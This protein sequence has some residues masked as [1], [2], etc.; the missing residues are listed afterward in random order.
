MNLIETVLKLDA[1]A[2]KG[3]WV[4]DLRGEFVDWGAVF[5]DI[6]VATATTLTGD[7]SIQK[8]YSSV[9]CTDAGYPEPPQ[10]AANANLIAL[11]RTAA[12]KLARALKDVSSALPDTGAIRSCVVDFEQ[13]YAADDDAKYWRDM[14]KDLAGSVGEVEDAINRVRMII[15]EV[16]KELA[17]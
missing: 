12:P 10:T 1:E 16:E 9:K 11:Y 5:S 15:A 17:P 7:I 13:S 8:Y 4:R 3:P 14:A 2:T 6:R